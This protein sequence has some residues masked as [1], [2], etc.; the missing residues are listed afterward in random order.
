MQSLV[1]ELWLVTKPQLPSQ[2]ASLLGQVTSQVLSQY[3]QV[4]SKSQG[5]VCGSVNLE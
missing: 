4:T 5:S 1:F 2:V 3:K